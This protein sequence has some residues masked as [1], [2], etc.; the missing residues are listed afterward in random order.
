ML[1][2]INKNRILVI[3]SHTCIKNKPLISYFYPLS[4]FCIIYNKK[5]KY[6]VKNT[7]QMETN[8][9]MEIKI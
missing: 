1:F 6:Y 4:N 5:K 9:R 2:L 8:F 3:K 7:N